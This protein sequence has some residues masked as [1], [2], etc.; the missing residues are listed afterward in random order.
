MCVRESVGE[1]ERVVK[2]TTNPVDE[3]II[4]VNIL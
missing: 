3:K 4:N 1:R 2:Y